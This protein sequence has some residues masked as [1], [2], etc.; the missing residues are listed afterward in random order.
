[1]IRWKDWTRRM[2]ATAVCGLACCGCASD[3]TPPA[4]A[5]APSKP[6][7]RR[8]EVKLGDI[9]PVLP[10]PSRSAPPVPAARPPAT[11]APGTTYTVRVG[12]TLYRIAES[13]YG[14]RS[15]WRDILDAN[16]AQLPSPSALKPGMVL[17]IP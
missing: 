12:D 10:G 11:V 17:V 5:P 3:S 4:P 6:V 9:T 8:G 1:M 16:R 7:L 13:V 14:D 2:A 15:R